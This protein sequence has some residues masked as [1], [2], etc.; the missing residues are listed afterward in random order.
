MSVLQSMPVPAD[1]LRLALFAALG[2]GAATAMA[3]ILDTL[4]RR[5]SESLR[6]GLLLA[7]TLGLIAVPGL[8]AI[9]LYCASGMRT[10]VDAP[11]DEVVKVPAAMLPE[12]LERSKYEEPQADPESPWTTL[13]GIALVLVWLGGALAGI[14]RLLCTVWRQRRTPGAAPWTAPF[15]TEGRR[16]ALARRLGMKRFPAVQCS[17]AVPMPMVKGIWRPTIVVPDPVPATWS[18][19]QWEAVLLH[20]A[21][22]IARRDPCAVLAQRLAVCLFWWLPLVYVMSRRLNALREAICDD[23]AVEGACDPIAYAELLVDSADHFLCLRSASLSLGLLDSARGG[24]E[25]RV[26]RLLEKEKPTMTRLSL[27]GKLLG[28]ACLVL[29]C[30]V[31]TA[32]TAVSGGPGPAPKK[33]QIKILIDGKEIDLDDAL[34]LQ[35]IE[36]AQKKA[37]A[38]KERDAQLGKHLAFGPDGKMLVR[39]DGKRI[40]VFDAATGKVVAQVEQPPASG[41]P[42]IEAL[43]K[44]AEA[45]KPGSGEAIRRALQATPKP[46]EPAKE[47]GVFKFKIAPPPP[48]GS[49]PFAG[50]KILIL[51]IEDGKV[52]MLNE[53]D[54]KELGKHAG[55][56]QLQLEFDHAKGVV[57]KAAAIQEQ[58]HKAKKAKDAAQA[59]ALAELLKKALAEKVAEKSPPP[60]AHG[61]LEALSRQ[62]ERLSTD[63]NELRKRLD[64]M[65]K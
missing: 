40:V 4:V 18:Q 59:A 25:V 44:Q 20:E 3:L 1:V 47:S 65:K 29:V 5:R 38:A 15:W 26:K 37:D 64:G 22:H 17:C 6:Y 14:T 32:G 54:L 53:G 43:V 61:D 21:A 19:S 30:L 12:L 39:G 11:A 60:A 9:G 41:D 10:L 50:K 16:S 31:T 24:L 42:R 51:Q 28:A 45:I 8:V 33:I 2:G 27:A 46:A 7:G 34:L 62:L 49:A 56:L 23:W 63:L 57:D 35:H 48:M 13:A 55:Q 58:L 36:A 52:L